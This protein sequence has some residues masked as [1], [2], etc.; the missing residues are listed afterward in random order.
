[1]GHQAI[2]INP[3]D[4]QRIERK[5]DAVL[6]PTATKT[7]L[8]LTRTEFE[9]KEGKTKSQVRYLLKNNPDLQVITNKGKKKI[10]WTSFNENRNQL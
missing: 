1:M 4:L 2:A 8:W 7:D 10:N 3:K 6:T 9:K 5:I